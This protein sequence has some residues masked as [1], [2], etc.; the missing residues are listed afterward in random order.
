MHISQKLLKISSWNF[1]HFLMNVWWT[2]PANFIK[3][4]DGRAG[5]IC[6]TDTEPMYVLRKHSRPWWESCM[7]HRVL[8]LQDQTQTSTSLHHN[9]NTNHVFNAAPQT[10]VK[11]SHTAKFLISAEN[12]WADNIYTEHRSPDLHFHYHYT[13]VNCC[14]TSCLNAI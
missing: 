5:A 1:V 9:T 13:V 14:S 12:S 4:W 11:P 3:F 10:R 8:G 2:L 7:L 6:W